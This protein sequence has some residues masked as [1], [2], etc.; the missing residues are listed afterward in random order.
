MAICHGL[1]AL[2]PRRIGDSG[3]DYFSLFH[4][5]VLLLTLG[6][7]VALLQSKYVTGVGIGIGLLIL[8]ASARAV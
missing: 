4:R 1:L 7:C 6:V 3:K 8:L 2:P 5:Y